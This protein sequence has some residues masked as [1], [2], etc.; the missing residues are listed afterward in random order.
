MVVEWSEFVP[1]RRDELISLARLGEITPEEAE[2]EAAANRWEP[3]AREP[4]PAE[5]DPMLEPRWSIVMA[6]AWIAWRDKRLV[7]E[8]WA[9]FRAEC[10]HWV[11]KPW[12]QPVE[13]GTRFARREGSFLEPWSG[14]TT[15]R[16]AL[17]ELSLTRQGQ[18][19]AT[20][21]MSV[22]KAQKALWRTLG[23]GTLVAEALDVD[24]KPVDVPKREWSHL[25]VFEEREQDALKYDANDRVQPFS[26][27]TFNRDKF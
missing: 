9:A 17:V 18:S 27:V 20:G 10:R 1:S 22:A 8:N 24:G 6:V 4:D 23:D 2:A 3:F 13:N 11:F 14:A 19:P 5:F 25:K 7:R 26:K 16:L 15:I 12:N 21:Q